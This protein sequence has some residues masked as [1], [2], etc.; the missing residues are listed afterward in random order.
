MTVPIRVAIADDHVMVISGVQKMLSGCPDVVVTGTYMNGEE[1]LRGLEQ[2]LPDV[3]L[4]DIQMPGRNGDELA[5]VLLEQYPALRILTL[6]NFDNTFYAKNM[7][8]HGALG[9]LLKR[10]DH[11]TLIQA[12][13]TVYEYREFLEPSM[14][15]QIEAAKLSK[16][17]SQHPVLTPREKEVLQLIV[18]GYTSQEIGQEL[19][20]G[21]RT[22]ENYRFS[23]LL[24]LDAKNTATLVKKA[25]QMGLAG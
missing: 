17:P 12:I 8:H 7:L 23:L 14:K 20:L 5:P 25:I 9:Y 10:T 13:K 6:T 22:V 4:L 3:L 11:E 18:N 15:Q 24:K 2:Q 21:Q 19:H 1:L 16:L